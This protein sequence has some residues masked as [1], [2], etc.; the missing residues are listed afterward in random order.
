MRW[1]VIGGG[2]MAGHMLVDYLRKRGAGELFFTSRNISLEGSLYLDVR[3]AV[4]T[5]ELIKSVSPDIIVNCTG[6]LNEEAQRRAADAF[7]INGL[8][9][10]RLKRAADRVGAR[11]VQISTDCVF[12]GERGNYTEWEPPDGHTVY[13]RSKALGEIVDHPHITVRTSIIGPEI[14]PHGIGL[15]KWIMERRGTV[16]GYA[17]VWWNGVTTLELAKAVEDLAHRTVSGLVHLH[18]PRK[19]SK[20]EL[21]RLICDIFGKRDVEIVPDGAYR[22]DRT[23]VNTR[24]DFP[25][26]V[27]D[28]PEM[29]QQLREWMSA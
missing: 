7:E 20:Y 2:G 29:L 16:K 27:P 25:R 4:A 3:D 18:A 24:S 28:Y 8:L 1:L 23:L 9:P 17:N 14:R 12:S 5:G 19:I 10:H 21:L 13:A 15:F 6:L 22:L 11:L 26:Q